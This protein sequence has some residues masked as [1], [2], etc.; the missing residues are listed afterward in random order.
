MK[1]TM[2]RISR[3]IIILTTTI[4][5]GCGDNGPTAQEK[6]EALLVSAQWK[7]PVVTVDGIDQSALYQ[8][9][10]IQ[11]GHNTYTS[12]GGEPLWPASGTWVFV[13]ENAT[14]LKL[15]GKLEIKISELTE[16]NLEL[17]FQNDNSTFT[18]G[19]SIKGENKFRLKK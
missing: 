1:N 14:T 4:L 6:T 2:T 15:D 16:T 5:L 11:F 12:S 10:K 19:R 18:S 3:A 13:D 17:I 9:F 8:N 7:N